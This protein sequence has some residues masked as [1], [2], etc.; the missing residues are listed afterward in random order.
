MF[1]SIHIHKKSEHIH[2]HILLMAF[3]CENSVV[4]WNPS[5]VAKINHSKRG[6]SI[7][8]EPR[9]GELVFWV[10]TAGHGGKRS[11]SWSSM[12]FHAFPWFL[13]AWRTLR[14]TENPSIFGWTL[15]HMQNGIE[16]VERWRFFVPRLQA[17]SVEDVATLVSFSFFLLDEYW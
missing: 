17:R 14:Y 4:D 13:D 7:G 1:I 12:V 9:C 3:F 11:W 2:I 8:F 6:A 10:R 16:R 15:S 5:L